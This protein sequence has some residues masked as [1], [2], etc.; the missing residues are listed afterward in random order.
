MRLVLAVPAVLALLATPALAT[1]T[2]DL[3]GA[4][5]VGTWESIDP[6]TGD[7]VFS[8]TFNADGTY[9]YADPS[10]GVTDG[11]YE[12]VG[13]TM[14]MEG[15]I[16]EG[17]FSSNTPYLVSTDPSGD[18]LF[19]M[20]FTPLAPG[21]GLVGTWT[22]WEA[23]SLVDPAGAVVYDYTNQYDVTL[24][25]DG[26]ASFTITSLSDP[27]APP[28]TRSGTYTVAGENVSITTT[29]PDDASA[30]PFQMEMQYVRGVLGIQVLTRA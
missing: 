6:A 22:S 3:G 18:R 15:L 7:V 27:T 29:D 11:T 8:E 25:A 26:T 19:S 17:R 14:K 20:S 21:A 2:A 23:A 28:Q 10:L 13:D 30:P 4:P 24:A 1:P 16:T 5:I 9:T 12:V